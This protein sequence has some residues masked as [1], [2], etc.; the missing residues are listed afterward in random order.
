MTET[1]CPD[2][3]AEARRVTASTAA[4]GLTVR[5]VGGLAIAQH[6]HD[7]Q[8]PEPL[9]R[10][11]G[12]IDIIVRRGDDRALR[13]HLEHLGYTADRRFNALHGA[14]RL[15][16]HDETNARRLDVFVGEFAMCHTLDL[17]GRL[18]LS[19]DSLA[20]ADLLLTKLQVVQL[21]HKDITDAATLLLTHDP[22]RIVVA[23]DSK[24]VIDTGRVIEV[25]TADWGWY[26]TVSDNLTAVASAAAGLLSRQAA[27]TVAARATAIT[28]AMAE[29]PKS[30]RWRLRAK[31]G[32]KLPWY[33]LPEEVGAGT[34]VA[35]G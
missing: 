30:M 31:I 3:E 9:H 16:Y 11:Y 7:I 13:A 27:E 1:P 12:D 17:A 18:D 33:E 35:H 29:A 15:L 6:R 8:V 5:L 14:R 28:R 4:A 22:E 20:A 21:T 25:T 24:C 19:P 2:I 32:R 23:A 26:T 34:G 10:D